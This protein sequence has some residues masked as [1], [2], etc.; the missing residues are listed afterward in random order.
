MTVSNALTRSAVAE[1][2]F[3]TLEFECRG[4]HDFVDLRDAQRVIGDYID[5][6]YNPERLHSTIDYCSPIEY[7]V[8][9]ALR[10]R[11]A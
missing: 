9:T 5:G 7:E 8:T 3:S 1:S 6:F 4:L 10:G 11:A 2:L